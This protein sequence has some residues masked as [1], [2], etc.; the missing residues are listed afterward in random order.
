MY[1][2]SSIPIWVYQISVYI[3]SVYIF[4]CNPFSR[5]F[6]ECRT[7]FP[8]FCK[9]YIFAKKIATSLKMG[10]SKFWLRQ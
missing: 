4:S 5:E 10:I 9:N 3:F 7:V 8:Q 2:F 6:F 1:I